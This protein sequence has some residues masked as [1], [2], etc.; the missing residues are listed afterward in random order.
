MDDESDCDEVEML[1]QIDSFLKN[2]SKNLLD[3]GVT[4]IA[5]QVDMSKFE[6]VLSRVL[7]LLDKEDLMDRF[8]GIYPAILT[9]T[10]REWTSPKDLEYKA[11]NQM[12]LEFEN[13]LMNHQQFSPADIVGPFI[14]SNKELKRK[15]IQRLI[16]SKSFQL[17]PLDKNGKFFEF[18][19]QIMDAVKSLG[20]SKQTLVI[21]LDAVVK[22]AEAL[23]ELSSEDIVD[24]TIAIDKSNEALLELVEMG[25]VMI[26]NQIFRSLVGDLLG[27]ILDLPG[28]LL[29]SGGSGSRKG[30]SGIT[31][32][33][34]LGGS[35]DDDDEDDEEYE[36]EPKPRRRPSKP[37]TTRRKG[38]STKS[39]ER[40]ADPTGSFE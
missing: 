35:N 24:A 40:K 21:P 25:E 3:N 18:K 16:R 11:F 15:A 8:G 5:S 26:V 1:C 6:H 30:G 31:I 34:G 29:G 14:I 33:I 12:S 13:L 38:S 17:K 7:G 20:N 32:T 10:T 37:T 27:V 36:E 39:I 4:K 2:I 23:P 9:Q 19:N 28:K 22:Q